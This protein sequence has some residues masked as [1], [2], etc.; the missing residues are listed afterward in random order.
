M[1]R[2][3]AI[4]ILAMSGNQASAVKLTT[5]PLSRE[6]ASQVFTKSALQK[7]QSPESGG[8]V[9]SFDWEAHINVSPVGFLTLCDT[10]T[11]KGFV[12]FCLMAQKDSGLVLRPLEVFKFEIP[13]GTRLESAVGESS[14]PYARH[15]K[16]LLDEYT[17]M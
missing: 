6:E 7:L 15:A 3:A 16:R 2:L 13:L 1:L 8:P 10:E 11:K 12:E 4:F 9:V 17:L 14:N 5:K